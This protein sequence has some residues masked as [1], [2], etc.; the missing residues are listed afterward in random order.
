MKTPVIQNGYLVLVDLS[1]YTSF[2]AYSELEHAHRILTELLTLLRGRLTP[3]LQ[4]AEIEGDALFLYA[5]R[6]RLARG[7]TLLELIESAYVAFRDNL[8]TMQRAATC[9]CQACQAA[10]NLDLKFVTHFGEYVL[11]DFGGTAKPIGSSVNLAHRLLKNPVSETTGWP[12]YALFTEQALDQM[13]LQ[14]LADIHKARLE[15]DH[16]G[17]CNVGAIDLIRRYQELT[18]ERTAFLSEKDAHFTIHRRFA[19][20]LP[21]LWELLNDP[22]LRSVWQVVSDWSP[23]SRPSGRTSEGA[24]NHCANSDFLEEVLDWRPFDYFTV[25][26]RRSIIRFLI[27]AELRTDGLHSELRWSIALEGSAPDRLRAALCR[28]FAQRLVRTAEGF[29]RLDRLVATELPSPNPGVG[30]TPS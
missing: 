18:A 27:T 1:G 11:Q 28:F 13:K 25:R 22:E 23:R 3:T 8:R 17:T 16:L 19:A 5:S 21:R 6:E 29:D 10:R 15:Y 30:T 12:A 4:L 24:Q 9:P 14:L 2:L 26:M 7:E 20:P